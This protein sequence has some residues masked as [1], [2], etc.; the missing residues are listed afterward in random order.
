MR[1]QSLRLFRVLCIGERKSLVSFA[2]YT[3]NIDARG[4]SSRWQVLANGLEYH[5]DRSLIRQPDNDW[6]SSILFA[7]CADHIGDHVR[8]S[9]RDSGTGLA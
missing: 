1:E 3:A 5:D 4:S 6:V 9:G 8:E 7:H 2:Y